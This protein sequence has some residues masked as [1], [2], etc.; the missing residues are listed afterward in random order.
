MS[1]SPTTSGCISSC[2]RVRS[3]IGDGSARLR[4][5]DEAASRER[6]S[7][8]EELLDR[9]AWV[10][11]G[12]GRWCVWGA[13]TGATWSGL[14]VYT[15]RSYSVTRP[16]RTGTAVRVGGRFCRGSRAHGR[17]RNG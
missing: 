9:L 4:S 13:K 14:L 11:E 16:P 7:E 12:C 8:M 3:V 17:R 6:P 1:S 5:S 10:R 2:S 15:A